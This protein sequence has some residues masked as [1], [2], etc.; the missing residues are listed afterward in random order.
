MEQEDLRRVEALAEW[1]RWSRR[2]ALQPFLFCTVPGLVLVVVGDVVGWV[3]LFW[4]GWGLLVA[5]VVWAGVRCVA[6]H[7]RL[8]E[9]RAELERFWAK[10]QQDER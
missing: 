5:A 7:R 9:S 6:S 4:L 8:R 3:W 10:Q 1:V 2:R